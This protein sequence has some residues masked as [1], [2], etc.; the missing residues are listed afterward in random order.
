M[1]VLWTMA[2]AHRCVTTDWVATTA[3]ATLGTFSLVMVALATVRNIIYILTSS[4]KCK[5]SNEIDL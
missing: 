4:N 2:T 3:V 1:S 5:K